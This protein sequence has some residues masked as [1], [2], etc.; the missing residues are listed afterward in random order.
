[1]THD[2]D[3]V[4]IAGLHLRCWTCVLVSDEILCIDDGDDGVEFELAVRLAL[5]LANLKGECRGKCR[6]SAS[7]FE[8]A[9]LSLA[10]VSGETHEVS[11]KILSG[12]YLSEFRAFIEPL[13]KM[14]GM[15][16]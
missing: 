6:A 3:D 9:L 8:C 15:G 5:E 14:M 1:M 11:M 2:Q 12:L 16:A 10:V 13:I 7:A 4:R